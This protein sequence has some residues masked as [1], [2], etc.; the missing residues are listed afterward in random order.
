MKP[1]RRRRRCLC[2]KALFVPQPQSRYH[3]RFCSQVACQKASKARSPRR[4]LARSGNRDYWRGPEQVARVQ[5]WRQTHRQYWKRPRRQA[6]RTLQEVCPSQPVVSQG[7]QSNLITPPL[8][9]DSF[10][11][12]PLVVGL[13]SMLTASTLQEDI[14]STHRRLVAR[15]Q[16]ILG[17]GPG[18]PNLKNH[19]AKKTAGTGTFA[20]TSGPI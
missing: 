15:G 12:H 8:Q 13:I 7:I 3:Q 18:A 6:R 10:T 17:M 2:C 5:A 16:E 11:Q 20:P 9:E 4:W 1:K 19:D 14:A